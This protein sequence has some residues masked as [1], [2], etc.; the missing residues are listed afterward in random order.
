MTEGK[1]EI[2]SH[3][4]LILLV[5]DQKTKIS[6]QERARSTAFIL[7]G[8]SRITQRQNKISFGEMKVFYLTV[9]SNSKYSGRLHISCKAQTQSHC[10]PP[11]KE[12]KLKSG[13]KQNS[14]PFAL[15]PLGITK[16]ALSSTKKLQ[17]SCD[18]YQTQCAF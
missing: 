13:I 7:S 12:G 17:S 4:E 10:E 3:L 14:P 5:K 8:K 9:I 6:L 15:Y 11:K 2:S 1:A 18:L 16:E